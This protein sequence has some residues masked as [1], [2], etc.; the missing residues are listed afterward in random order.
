MMDILAPLPFRSPNYIVRF[1]T[2][3]WE[4]AGAAALRRAVFCGEQQIFAGDDRDAIDRYAIPIVAISTIAGQLDMV[5]GV[6]RIHEAEPAQWWGSRLA[7]AASHRNAGHIGQ[8]L[9]RL[10]VCSANA[11]GCRRFLAHVQSQNEALFQRL[12]WQTQRQETLH[13]RPH[14]LMRADLS[15]YPPV[16]DGVTGFVIQLRKAA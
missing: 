8:A 1:A 14:A 12:H 2:E 11:R 6:V 4:L 16:T 9:I 13:G 15:Y 10:A 5:V 3:C 7:V